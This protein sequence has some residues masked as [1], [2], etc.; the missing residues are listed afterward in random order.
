MPFEFIPDTTRFNLTNALCLAE[1]SALAYEPSSVI[2]AMTIK[3]WG[4]KRCDCFD[5]NDT[6]V[7]IAGN[8][9]IILLSFRGTASNEDWMT[10][11][12]TRLIPYKKGRVHR[13]FNEAFSLTKDWVKRT[14]TEYDDRIQSLWVT[15]H[16]LGAALATLAVDYLIDK[17]NLFTVNGLYTF[18]SPRV[19]DRKF[20][21]NFDDGIKHR[22]FRFVYDEDVVTRVPPRILGYEH[23]GTVRY[24]DRKGVLQYNNVTWKRWLDRTE[25][26]T[27]RSLDRYRELKHQY[28]GGLHDHGMYSYIRYIKKNLEKDNPGPMDF[29]TYINQ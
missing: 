28:P 12:K 26:V 8:D 16:S 14:I 7:F 23:V 1:A 3:Q 13:G 27:I 22:T 29:K 25:S 10:D 17:E 9:D 21:E 15:G 4:M 20:A 24:I 2:K 6:Q 11:S 18:G 5:Q 19:G